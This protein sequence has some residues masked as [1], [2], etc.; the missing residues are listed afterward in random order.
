MKTAAALIVAALLGTVACAPVVQGGPPLDLPPGLAETA[1]IGTVY[2]SSEWLQVE[3]DFSDTFV[4]EVDEEMQMCAYGTYPLD[5]RLHV[6]DVRRAGRFQTAVTGEGTH[7]IRAVA[8]L[9]DPRRDNLIV[10]RYP[11]IVEVDAGGRLAGVFGDRQMIAAEAFGRALCDAAFA[12]NPR[13]PGP[14]NA[15]PG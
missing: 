5:L 12:R 4:E 9:V 3:E 11:L 8:E 6:E 10:G 7:E 2:M 1:Q 13:R 15:T 14:H